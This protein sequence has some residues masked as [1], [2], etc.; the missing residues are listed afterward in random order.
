MNN[1]TSAK[2]AEALVRELQYQQQHATH[3]QV[4]PTPA[5]VLERYRSQRY[6]RIVHK[7]YLYRA[8]GNLEG[9]RILDFG[10]GDGEV[11]V[12][13]AALGAQVTG[14]DISPELIALARRRASLDG[15]SGRAEFRTTDIVRQPPPK[16]SFDAVTCFAV[17]HHVDYRRVVPVLYDSLKPG[18]RAV[19]AE[20]IALSKTMRKIRELLPVSRDV[21]PDERQFNTEEV[22]WMAGVF[23]RPEISYW[24]L[25][26]RLMRFLPG[27]HVLE[28]A[29][30]W[31]RGA[32]LSLMA[33]DRVCAKVPFLRRYFGV[34]TIV[35]RK[36]D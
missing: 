25:F 1:S 29:P 16:N 31:S 3:V 14:V 33:F 22:A 10:C 6:S 17:L 11:A 18:G 24:L 5:G 28:K 30:A 19:I 35:G 12:Q 21:S 36:E 23:Q 15:V 20:P 2:S 13:L 27:G 7:D 9:A 34:V 8:L 26:G 4:A 32:A